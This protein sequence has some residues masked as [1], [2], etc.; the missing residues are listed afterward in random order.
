MK[1]WWSNLS[2]RAKLQLPI[3]L[4]LLLVM[5]SAQRFAIDKFEEHVL[6][7]TR[8]AALVSA[9]GVLNGLNMLMINGIISDV[10]QRALYIEKMGA[11]EKLDELR[12]IRGK[13]IDD[14]FGPGQPSE[15][16]V[17][18]LDTAA[19]EQGTVQLQHIMHDNHRALRIVVPFTA[20]ENFRGT[21]CLMCHTVP[22]GTVT[23]AT[24]V[25]LN[26]SEEFAL[27]AK[28]NLWAWALQITLQIL[29]YFLIGRLINRVTS[30][31][32]QSVSVANRIAAGD[33]SSSITIESNDEVGQQLRA[34]HEM[35]ASLQT[36][37]R[38]IKSMVQAAV[39][40]DFSVKMEVNGKVG[41]S[42]ELADLLNQLSNTV[43]N[44]FRDTI[45]VTTA[46]AHGDLEQKITKEYA[47]AYGQVKESVNTTAMSLA[48]IVGE[49]KQVVED[50]AIRGNFSSK[51]QLDGKVGYIREL[52][53]L[54]NELSH[55]TETGINDVVRVANA[56][57]R[58]DLTLSITNTHP[59]SFGEMGDS[60]NT[61][62]SHLKELVIQIRQA[63]DTIHSAAGEISEGNRDLSERT[64]N[65]AANLEKIASSMEQITATVKQ[66][67]DSAKHANQLAIGS[68]EV[69]NK[70]GMVVSQVMTTMDSI[71]DSSRKIE[72]IISVIDGI[73]FQTNILALNAAVE[74]AHAGEQ[75][76]GFAVVASEV[77]SLAQRSAAAAREIK[78]LINDSVTQIEEGGRL[79]KQAGS[80]MEEIVSS[81][82]RVTDIM[83]EIVFASIEQSSDIE[84]INHAIA[85]MDQV[86][87][88]NT[89]LVEEAA[90]AARVLESQAEA[91]VQDVAAFK[92]SESAQTTQLTLPNRD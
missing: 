26:V 10:G 53:E 16:A 18:E 39:Q 41:Y 75:G 34:M 2:I 36:L 65:Q 78:S 42:K 45:R 88:Q 17:D 84:Q 62:V 4:L 87:Q 29:L 64:E 55:V 60:M 81:T 91:L 8:R 54:L 72:A 59:G 3:Q 43:D 20:T 74:A 83:S 9:D 5:L 79:V 14:Q 51:L 35:Q 76:R 92:V 80:T 58:G 89:A 6:E 27:I 33:L 23:G 71:H 19:I 52:S 49:I 1:K 86:T 7:E 38:E 47:G 21:N 63:T 66:S 37:I 44:A 50:A 70:G 67:A 25:T 69:A 77:R 85:Q 12:V 82:H 68:S 31:V 32:L 13:V 73:A 48:R 30:P 61:T 56:L 11:S 28:V 22:E 57:A 15:R 40:G 90:A 46:L 24:S